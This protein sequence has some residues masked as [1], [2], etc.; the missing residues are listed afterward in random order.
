[1]GVTK[2]LSGVASIDPL[3]FNLI[4]PVVSFISAITACMNPN[5]FWVVESIVSLFIGTPSASIIR[6]SI[7]SPIV[8]FNPSGIPSTG[9]NNGGGNGLVALQLPD[10]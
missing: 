10:N 3:F 1:M 8:G 5:L 4:T 6:S 2:T 7:T 9:I